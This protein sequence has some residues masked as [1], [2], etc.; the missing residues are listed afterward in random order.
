MGTNVK[1]SFVIPC[2]NSEHTIEEVVRG[3]LK[4]ED[5][6][7]ITEEIILV[8]DSSTDNTYQIIAKLAKAN[9]NIVCVNLAKNFGQHAALMAGFSYVKGDLVCCLDDDGQTPPEEFPKLYQKLVEDDDD[10]VYARYE[11]KK[12]SLFRN[13]GSYVN[14]KMAQYLINKPG[15]L[16]ISSYFLAKKFVI[17]N[18]LRYKNAYPYVM[19]L[20]LQST[21]KIGN[22]DVL[23]RARVVSE[24]GYSLKKLLSLWLNGF[25]SFSVKPLRMSTILGFLITIAGFIGMVCVLVNKL[26][27]PDV[28][29]GWS[30]IIAVILLVGGLLSL[31]LGLIGEYVGRIY[32]CINNAPQYVVSETV[33]LR[34]TDLEV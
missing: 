26:M 17:D 12:H 28:P 18:V 21:K 30:S 4:L 11:H 31:M 8:N 23:H 20:V 14:E 13:F 24:S 9:K 33:D 15:E 34:M 7:G 16:Y 29:L 6:L 1:V 22:A 10:V 32:I 5:S 27:N 3:I 2:Y 25:T 19:G